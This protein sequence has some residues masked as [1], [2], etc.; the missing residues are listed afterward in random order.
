MK[1]CTASAPL[2]AIVVAPELPNTTPMLVVERI[3][4]TDQMAYSSDFASTAILSPLSPP[5]G[6]FN[7][8][9]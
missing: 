8:R 7:L 9:I 2:P 1:C 5:T 6:E 3:L 4:A